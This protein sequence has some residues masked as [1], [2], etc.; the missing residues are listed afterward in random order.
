MFLQDLQLT[1]HE[2]IDLI[3]SSLLHSV[4]LLKRNPC[5]VW[6][7]AF[8]KQIPQLWHANT[9]AQFILNA[10]AAATYCSSYMT[11]MDHS[12]T[13]AFKKI[14]EDC[15]HNSDSKV[16]TIRKLG[17]ALLNMQ[18]MSSR[19]AIY[20][21]LSLPLYSSSR[22]T[23]FLNTAT[24]EKR[25]FVLK[26]PHIL[27][28][29]PDDSEDIMCASIIDKYLA[30]PLDLDQTC[31][32]EYASSYSCSR[33]K[34]RKRKCPYVIRYILYNEHKD[35]KNHFREKLMLF[36]PYRETEN[37]LKENYQTWYEAYLSHKF[38]I[39][40][41]EKQILPHTTIA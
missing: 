31:L 12:M 7:N 19:Q 37:S 25:R 20:I 36:V 11:K 26:K 4:L 23:I 29:E 39:D 3:H 32:A 16:E 40:I 41:V 33:S 9:D 27:Q 17:N 24:S 14:R 10:H 22:K 34:I 13:S 5:D 30:C 35:T 2:Y 38:D 6:I 8:A 18:Q 28:Q 1:K 15:C 21:V